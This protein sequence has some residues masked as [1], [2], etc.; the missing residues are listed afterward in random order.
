[1]FKFKMFAFTN[2]EK[3]RVKCEIKLQ[4]V[5]LPKRFPFRPSQPFTKAQLYKWKYFEVKTNILILLQPVCVPISLF[6]HR[7]CPS[8]SSPH[9]RATDFSAKRGLENRVTSETERHHSS[10]TVPGDGEDSLST[11]CFQSSHG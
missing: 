1:M 3:Q 2:T 6:T 4:M 7:S 8:Q 5:V 11:L 9:P 10:R